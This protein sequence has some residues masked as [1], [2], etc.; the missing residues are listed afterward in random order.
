MR[1]GYS[2]PASQAKHS[3][4]VLYALESDFASRQPGEI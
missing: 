1:D 4:E 2:R 3:I